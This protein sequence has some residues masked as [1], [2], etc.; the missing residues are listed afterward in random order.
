VI[1]YLAPRFAHEEGGYET[2]GAFIFYDAPPLAP[3]GYESARARMI[4]LLGAL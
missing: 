2:G 4:E 3:G 1:G